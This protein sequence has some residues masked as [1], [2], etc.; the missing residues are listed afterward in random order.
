MN[1]LELLELQKGK[2]NQEF[3][4][5][6]SLR[7]IR[8]SNDV[9]LKKNFYADS[10]APKKRVGDPRITAISIHPGDKIPTY[11]VHCL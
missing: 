2:S 6:T 4:C 11:K 10:K 9:D 3:W 5:K 8:T 7:L 1:H